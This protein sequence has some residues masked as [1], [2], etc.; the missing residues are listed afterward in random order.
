MCSLLFTPDVFPMPRRYSL[1]GC[2]EDRTTGATRTSNS[3]EIRAAPPREL[4]LRRVPPPPA[5]PI[6]PGRPIGDGR[7]RL[8]PEI[9]LRSEARQPLDPDPTRRIRSE[10]IINPHRSI[11]ILRPESVVRSVVRSLV[12][13]VCRPMQIRRTRLK[14]TVSFK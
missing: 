1:A 13:S 4:L 7:L 3:G 11:L 14:D 9:T 6:H 10:F 5:L 8:D 12:R 2:R